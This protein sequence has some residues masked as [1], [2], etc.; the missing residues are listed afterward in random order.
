MTP[1]LP[2]SITLTEY[3]PAF[4][5]PQEFPEAIAEFLYREHHHKLDVEWPSPKTDRKW[6]LT[7]QGWVGHIPV[8]SEFRVIIQ[9]KVTIGNLFRMLEYA[10]QLKSFHFPDGLTTCDSLS[11]FYERLANVLAKRI[12]DRGRKGFYRNYLFQEEQLPYVRGRLNVRQSLQ[13]PWAVNLDCRYEEHSADIE[14]NQLLLWTLWRIL[15][16]GMCT[17]RVIPTVRRAYRSLQGLATLTGFH[18]NDCVKRLY[19]RL[20]EDY[21]PLHALCRFFLEHSGPSHQSGDRTMLPFLIDM[22]RLYERFTAEWL[23]LHL[24]PGFSL[25]AQE[26][27]MY[28]EQH[29]RH[30]DIDLVLSNSTTGEMWVL[31]TKYKAPKEPSQA[32]INQVTTY[33]VAKNCRNAILIYPTPLRKPIDTRIG[34]SNI[35]VRN[36]T[37]ALDGDLEQAGQRFLHDLL[38]K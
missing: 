4:F 20:N 36:V 37:F 28:D 25:Q 21:V 27:V 26:K 32:D 38:H 5:A 34:S 1:T 11:E 24:S 19:N 7:P 23:K 6:R 17:E 18:P 13:T 31:D 16:S 9:P 10:Y 22:A 15:R 8:T 14:E 30:L 3:N 12:L 35:R 33:A 29:I 2:K